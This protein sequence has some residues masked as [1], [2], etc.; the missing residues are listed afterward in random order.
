M[1]RKRLCVILF[2]SGDV[3]GPDARESVLFVLHDASV[4]FKTLPYVE[5]LDGLAEFMTV[6]T[7]AIYINACDYSMIVPGLTP[8]VLSHKQNVLYFAS[9]AHRCHPI[10]GF[11]T[12]PVCL[13]HYM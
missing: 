13:T 12:L 8:L 7:S 1:E 3:H 2:L 4:C 6:S 9:M 11:E 10:E 5:M